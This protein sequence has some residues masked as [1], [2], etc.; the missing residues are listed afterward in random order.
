MQ[1]QLATSVS[2]EGEDG[3]RLRRRAGI[4]KELLDERVHAVRV[5]P[6]RLAPAFAAGRCSGELAA[7][8]LEARST[9]HAGVVARIGLG[10]VSVGHR[11]SGVR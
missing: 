11:V 3:H 5:L 7:C 8:G 10:D 6:H 9:S 4:G 1:A 2:A